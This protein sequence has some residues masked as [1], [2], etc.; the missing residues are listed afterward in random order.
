LERNRPRKKRYLR[1][2]ITQ[3]LILDTAEEVFLEKGYHKTTVT[4]VSKRAN[5]GYG[6]IY[7]H[8][9]GKD[10]LLINII[11]RVMDNFFYVLNEYKFEYNDLQGL[12]YIIEKRNREILNLGVE[13]RNILKVLYEAMYLS[14]NIFEHWNN[15]QSNFIILI[16]SDVHSARQDGYVTHDIDA[17]VVAKS[18]VL[19]MEKFLWEVVYER[20]T[21]IDALVKNLTDIFILGTYV[22]DSMLAKP[23]S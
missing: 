9:Q 10:D 12:Y 13:N 4:E 17:R 2:R 6:T 11:M 22:S 15:T 14:N 21:D 8:F 5:V 20:E 1:S 7:S 23:T 19:T 18:E 3:R 16:E